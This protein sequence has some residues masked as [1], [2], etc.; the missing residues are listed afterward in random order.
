MKQARTFLVFLALAL[1]GWQN[2]AAQQVGADPTQPPAVI[3]SNTPG[4]Q[5]AGGSLLQS[6]IIT[7]T[8]RVAIIGGE[9]VSLGGKYGDARVV[10]ITANEVVL[11]SSTG[12]ETLRMYPDVEIKP[13]ES[14]DIIR[15]KKTR[16]L[17]ARHKAQGRQE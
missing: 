2:A 11:R 16:G 12:A 1:P 7:P 10:K 17:P 3:L 14:E 8:Q 15:N 5:G 9:R 4:A 6:V 13:V